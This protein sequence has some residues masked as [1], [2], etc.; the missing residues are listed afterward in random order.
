MK[1]LFVT[2]ALILVCGLVSMPAGAQSKLSKLVGNWLLKADMNGQVMESQ[3]TVE[4]TDDGVFAVVEFG[5]Q[6]SD[7][8]EIKEVEGRL[9]SIL[10]IPEVGEDIEI[11]YA[12]VDDDTVNVVVDAGG[13][14]MEAPM[15][16]VKE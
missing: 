5:G 10:Q 11:S 3:C 13:F 2:A 15:T 12:I 1:K 9:F 7:K 14:V 4:Q 6:I 8:I 16:R